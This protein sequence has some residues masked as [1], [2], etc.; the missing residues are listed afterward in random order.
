MFGFLK[1]KPTAILKTSEL[2]FRKIL[3]SKI[4]FDAIE[5][6]I[7][8]W[9]ENHFNFRVAP[10]R[11][12]CLGN[13]IF[14]NKQHYI[15]VNGDSSPYSFLITLIHE[16]AHQHVTI[17]NK[18]RKVSPH[19]AE[20][21]YTFKILMSPFLESNIFPDELRAILIKHMQNPAASS[22]KDP[23]L[24]KALYGESEKNEGPLLEDIKNGE[25]FGFKNQIY[26]KI[27]KRRS[28]TLVESV[29]NKKQYTIPSHAVVEKHAE[30]LA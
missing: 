15:T 20:W 21:K 24:M 22:T 19:G 30:V 28:R 8:I 29:L 9:A 26:K 3:N 23:V 2:D 12:S 7:N 25:L 27:T 16:I 10:S 11:K 1:K 6:V 13:Y 18:F 4:P 14:K 5:P 17:N